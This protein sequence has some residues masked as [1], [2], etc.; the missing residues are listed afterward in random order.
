MRTAAVP[1]H[2]TREYPRDSESTEQY[3]SLAPHPRLLGAAEHIRIKEA[4]APELGVLIIDRGVCAIDRGESI[5]LA[6]THQPRRLVHSVE[7]VRN[8]ALAYAMECF[9]EAHT[10]A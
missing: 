9:A 8:S 1:P 2:T 3:L 4:Y 7:V 5:R 6:R 10:P